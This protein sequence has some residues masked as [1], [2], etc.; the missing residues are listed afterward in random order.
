MARVAKLGGQAGWQGL[1]P[2]EQD[3]C[4]FRR[5]DILLA[6]GL[7]AAKDPEML[8]CIRWSLVAS[9]GHR[10]VYFLWKTFKPL[11]IKNL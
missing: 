5:A 2:G 6:E 3:I 10:K 4:E 8:T 11:P 9:E 7:G 1:A